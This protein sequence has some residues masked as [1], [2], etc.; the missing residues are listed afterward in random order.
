MEE[1]SPGGAPGRTRTRCWRNG[2]RW[3]TEREG[4]LPVL[5]AVLLRSTPGM[6]CWC[7]STETH[8]WLLPMAAH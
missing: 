8:E 2:A 4:L 5:R 6:C 7:C 3:L 1:K